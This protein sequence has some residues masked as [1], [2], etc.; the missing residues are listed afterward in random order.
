[1]GE[2]ARLTKS[3]LT[4]SV[5]TLVKLSVSGIQGDPQLDLCP[6]VYDLDRWCLL[7]CPKDRILDLVLIILLIVDARGSVIVHKVFVPRNATL[8]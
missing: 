2:P 1:M 3:V 5:T 4:G 7:I 6:I 8:R